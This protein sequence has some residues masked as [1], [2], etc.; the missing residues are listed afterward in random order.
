VKGSFGKK[1]AQKIIDANLAAVKRG[2][3]EVK[4]G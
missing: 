2:Y 4:Q 3:E 1:F